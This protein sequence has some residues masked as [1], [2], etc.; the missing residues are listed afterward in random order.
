MGIAPIPTKFRNPIIRR[1][2]R[3]SHGSGLASSVTK[4]NHP[5][6]LE[7]DEVSLKVGGRTN[8]SKKRNFLKRAS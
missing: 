3:V 2:T 8:F 4:K 5:K 7:F 1:L 6:E